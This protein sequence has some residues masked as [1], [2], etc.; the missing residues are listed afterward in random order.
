MNPTTYADLT[1]PE[2]PEPAVGGR[3]YWV[4]C[5]TYRTA[6]LRTKDGKWVALC[7]NQEITDV[8]SFL[9]FK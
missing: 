1:R 4:Q 7:N 6:A 2:N 5:E 9:P 8:I 3:E